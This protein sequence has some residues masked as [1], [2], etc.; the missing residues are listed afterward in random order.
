MVPYFGDFPTNHTSV[1]IP[2]N[3]FTSNDPAASATITDFANTDVHIHKN[4][5]L[6]QRASSAGVAID[7]DVDAITGGHWVTIDLSDNTDAGFYAA[8][9]E[10]SV[11]IEGVT[12][13]GATVNAFIGS[14]SIE[15]AGGILALLKHADYGLAQ[16]IRSTTPANKLT[17]DANGE[18]TV[19][20]TQ[21]VDVETVKTQAVTCAAPV[22]VLASVGT[23]ATSTAQTGDSFPLVSTEVAEIYAAVITNAAGV[24]IAA[25]IIAVKADTAAILL[26]TGTD[27]VVLPQA[28]A[29]KVWGT[30]ARIL[31]ANTN[32]NDPTA[33]TIADAVWDE[34][35]AGHAG[36][37]STG[38]ALSDAGA[39]GVPPTVG[40][41]ADAV[42]DELVTG[43][44][45]AGKAGAQLWTDIDA[46]AVDVAGLDGAAMRGTDSAALASVCTEGRLS[47]LD[48]IT[49]GKMAYVADVIAVDVAG[50][51]G[52]AMRGTDSAALASVCTEARLAELDAANLPANIDTIA[53]DVAGLDGAA[54]R[55]TDS[56]AL[57]SVCTEG[58][59]AELDAANLPTDV[60][61]V[62]KTTTTIADGDS[63]TANSL[64][65]WI[66]R[67]RW[68]LNNK[69]AVVDATGGYTL[70]KDDGTTSAATGT[71][72]DD[73]TTTTRSVPTWA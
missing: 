52:A 58:R 57:A 53:V 63:L 41:I 15:R 24:D 49:A 45:G 42:W 70:Y 27:G 31:T 32:F 61:N 4:G 26:D 60:T 47:E 3:A 65:L 11:R 50:L 13:D 28:Q 36:V 25:D 2:F 1:V 16:L 64:L 73:S 21:K 10:I 67:M 39:A 43:H 22:T 6:T 33:A 68:M 9:S 55:G 29:D 5:S 54:M 23:A 37:G 34:A 14:F 40:E 19:P 12:I 7:I 8:G 66:R 69:M 35:I 71:V 62:V 48:A 38:E 56:A 17:V 59:L 44:D 30:A 18:V 20:D 46:I 72:T 51:D